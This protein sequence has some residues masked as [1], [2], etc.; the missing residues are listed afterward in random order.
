MNN[1]EH[2]KYSKV[3]EVNPVTKQ[4]E[5]EYTATPP[6]A[7]YGD[8]GGHAQRLPNGNTLISVDTPTSDTS[9][10]CM[11]LEVT[12][13]KEVVW[14]WYPDLSKMAIQGLYRVN[15][16][17]KKDMQQFVAKRF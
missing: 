5:W 1:S 4:V 13:N 2:T 14:E 6:Q 9:Q 15:R 7:M 10:H 8:Y 12:R 3:I 17:A 16:V 11:V